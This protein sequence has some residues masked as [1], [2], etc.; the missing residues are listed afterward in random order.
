M[1]SLGGDSA[2]RLIQKVYWILSFINTALDFSWSFT[3]NK[4]V[5][6]FRKVINLIS[7]CE[8]CKENG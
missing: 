2:Q 1:D 7:L 4:E 5:K 3:Q 8:M 6:I